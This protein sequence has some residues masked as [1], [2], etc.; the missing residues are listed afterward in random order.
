VPNPHIQTPEYSIKR[1]RSDEVELPENKI[2]SYKMPERP[3][4][5]DPTGT[6]ASS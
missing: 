3:Q 1:V 6:R 5:A 2:L 4:V